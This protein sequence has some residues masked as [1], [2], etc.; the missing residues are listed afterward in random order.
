VARGRLKTIVEQTR[1]AQCVDSDDPR[2][3]EK[4][5]TPLAARVY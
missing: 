3:K 5:R 1:H 2:T 4:E